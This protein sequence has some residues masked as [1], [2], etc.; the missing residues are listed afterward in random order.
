MCEYVI[1]D[2][3]RILNLHRIHSIPFSAVIFIIQH[4]THRAK[5]TVREWVRC[6]PAVQMWLWENRELPLCLAKSRLLHIISFLLRSIYGWQA[7]AH[8]NYYERTNGDR[9]A[10]ANT[11][12]VQFAVTA[13][14]AH[15]REEKKGSCEQS[16]L[17][18]IRNSPSHR[19]CASA[20]RGVCIYQRRHFVFNNIIYDQ[21]AAK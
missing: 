20:F 8:S 3:V 12:T 10:I 6:A 18:E 17:F 15:N 4:T 9:D 16:F 11:N 5:A 2:N 14:C 21:R 1:F 7:S 19:W 13:H